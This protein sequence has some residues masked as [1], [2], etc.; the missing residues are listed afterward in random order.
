M[1]MV[2]SIKESILEEVARRLEEKIENKM[3]EIERKLVERLEKKTQE[4]EENPP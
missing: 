2:M 4:Q 3:D 1:N